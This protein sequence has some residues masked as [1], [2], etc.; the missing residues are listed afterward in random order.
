MR[1][2]TRQVD[3]AL[4]ETSTASL[5]EAIGFSSPHPGEI[6]VQPVGNNGLF[7]FSEAFLCASQNVAVSYSPLP[8]TGSIFSLAMLG[9]NLPW[10]SVLFCSTVPV[11]AATATGSSSPPLIFL[12][13]GK[14]ILEKA[15]MP[16]ETFIVN[17]HSLVA[18]DDQVTLTMRE[19]VT[20]F[21]PPPSAAGLQVVIKGPGMIYLSGC[22]ASH[23]RLAPGAESGLSRRMRSPNTFGT[24]LALVRVGVVVVASCLLVNFFFNSFFHVYDTLAGLDP[25]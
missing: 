17:L 22:N 10:H 4:Y 1:A 14:Q 25:Q 12:Q 20:S 6:L 19:K 2:V 18:F 21:F 16:T 24:V 9:S 3:V 23:T 13:S 11:A 5:L 15:L 7:I 8:I